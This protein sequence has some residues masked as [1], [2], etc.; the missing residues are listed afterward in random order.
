M[1]QILRRLLCLIGFH[2][3]KVERPGGSYYLVVDDQLILPPGHAPY[4]RCVRCDLMEPL[5]GAR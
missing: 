5:G 3:W 2:R 4:Y 1:N